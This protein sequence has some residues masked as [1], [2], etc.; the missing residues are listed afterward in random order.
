MRWGPQSPGVVSA[1]LFQRLSSAEDLCSWGG[2]EHFPQPSNGLMVFYAARVRGI[3][4]ICDAV[5]D[6][7]GVTHFDLLPSRYLHAGLRPQQ[8]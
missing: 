6:P 4:V 7:G 1:L 5:G 3:T 8:D 2:L